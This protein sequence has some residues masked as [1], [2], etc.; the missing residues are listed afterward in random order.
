MATPL[1]LVHAEDDP[2]LSVDSY[3]VALDA[4]KQGNPHLM[5]AITKEGGHVGW[6]TGLDPTKNRW[7]WMSQT[8]IDYVIA[9][10]TLA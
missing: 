4:V 8:A 3:D 5:V 7:G 9:C 2:I 10:D 6:P 1:L